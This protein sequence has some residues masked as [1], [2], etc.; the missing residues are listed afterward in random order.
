MDDAADIR[1]SVMGFQIAYGSA[2][3]ALIKTHPDP[4]ALV[5]A[6]NLE[7]QESIALLTA[8]M[9]PDEVIEA[10]HVAWTMVGPDPS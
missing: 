1:A 9:A 4:L 5:G 10:F 7:H 8:S 3:R 2:M 6:M